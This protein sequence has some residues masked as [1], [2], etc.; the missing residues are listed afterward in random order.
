MSALPPKADIANSERHI[1]FVPKA[2]SCTAAIDVI[3]YPAPYPRDVVVIHRSELTTHFCFFKGNV[4][5]ISSSEQ[6]YGR[7]KHRPRA[8]PDCNAKGKKNEAQIHWI[9]GKLIWTRS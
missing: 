1:R 5:P 4:D 2:D 6:G 7:T 9:T 8:D 3:S